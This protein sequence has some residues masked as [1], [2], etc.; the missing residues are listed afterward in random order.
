MSILNHK[1]TIEE[2]Y[3][4]ILHDKCLLC[5]KSIGKAEQLRLK[6]PKIIPLCPNH[7]MDCVEENLRLIRSGEGKK[8]GKDKRGFGK[9]YGGINQELNTEDEDE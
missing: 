1:V 4:S 5:S 6:N 8:V 3:Q 9:S 2:L 7:R